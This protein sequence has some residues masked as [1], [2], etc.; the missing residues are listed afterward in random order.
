V[1][2]LKAVE[3]HAELFRSHQV[4]LSGGQ[5][6]LIGLWRF[7]VQSQFADYLIMD[8]PDAYLDIEGL[9]HV[10]PKV[11]ESFNGKT[12][13]IVSHNAR[14]IEQCDVVYGLVDGQLLRR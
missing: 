5:R 4:L 2:K 7:A 8:E 11:F 3:L 14:I 12:I 6:Q 1:G 10:L 13:M 9:N